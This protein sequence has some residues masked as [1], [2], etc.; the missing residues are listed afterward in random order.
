MADDESAWREL[1]IMDKA[2]VERHRAALTVPG[3]EGVVEDSTSGSTGHKFVFLKDRLA[4]EVSR[5]VEFLGYEMA[6]VE[7]GEKRLLL[8]GA[9]RDIVRAHPLDGLKQ[10]GLAQ[11]NLLAYDLTDSAV[12]DL[13]AEIARY[14]PALILAYPNVLLEV[15]RKGA[16]ILRA[17]GSVKVCMTSGE[18]M[19]TDVRA[20]L[21]RLLE[22]PVVDRY[23]SREF[24]NMA[25]QCA[26][27]GGFHV[28]TDRVVLEVVRPDGTPCAH[29][30]EG[31]VVVTDLDL[32]ALPLVRYRIG[33]RAVMGDGLCPCGR[34]YPLLQAIVGRCLDVVL[35]SDGGAI[36]PYFFTHLARAV[37]GIA[38]FR[39][40]QREM[41]KATIEVVLSDAAGQA[42][43]EVELEAEARRAF[44]GRLSVDV[45]V[46]DRLPVT[47]AGK[48]RFIESTVARLQ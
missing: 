20:R 11:R 8:W 26:V 13:L 41:G 48:L 25:Q 10:W 36:A 32:R 28:F 47:N 14:R 19:R 5:A 17:A 15:A 34:G 2:E 27:V 23:G 12:A 37:P 22:C 3:V 33:D 39:V 21:E 16:D 38:N 44:A 31:D 9:S 40:V 42:S 24:G 1:P 4:R 45:R 6:G 18:T 30:E 7:L 46:V 35:A 29:G 43:A